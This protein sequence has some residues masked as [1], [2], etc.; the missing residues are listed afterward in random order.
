MTS[1]FCGSTIISEHHLL[2][3]SHCFKN[4]GE[5]TVLSPFTTYALLGAYDLNRTKESVL[6]KAHVSSIKIHSDWN[7]QIETY[8]A[9]IAI[10]SNFKPPSNM[11]AFE[12]DGTVVG[13]GLSDETSGDHEMTP[14]FV[15]ISSV[16]Q[17]DC[18]IGRDVIA[19]IS[20]NRMFC[21][22]SKWKNP[23]RV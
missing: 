11:N 10:L 14:K 13:Y 2:S 15:K 7:T 18:L 5:S 9:D 4:K 3:A 6:I 8:D 20:S 12:I 17:E 1:F 22:G 16:T 21:A 23:C 19:R